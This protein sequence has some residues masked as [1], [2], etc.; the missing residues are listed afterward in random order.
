MR[1]EV[2]DKVIPYNLRFID[3]NNFVIGSLE[4]HV[5][6]L[7]ELYDCDCTGKKKQQIKIKHDD[8]IINTRYK[9]C[10]KRSKQWIELLKN[11]FPSTFCLVNGNIDKFI[12]L[13]KKGVSP[14]EYMTDCENLDET[15]LP[16]HN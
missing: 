13:L 5:N 9:T 11:K 14:Y 4:N 1:K 3:S 16:S 7:S 12:L 6:N 15:E 2:N 10:T 8:K